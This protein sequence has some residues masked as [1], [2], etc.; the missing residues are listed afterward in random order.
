MVEQ[1]LEPMYETDYEGNPVLDDDGNKIP[2]DYGTYWI[3]EGLEVK[4][5]APTQADVDK[6]MALYN[7]IDSIYRYDE[8]VM[9]SITEVAGQYFAGDK[10]LDDAANLIQSKVKLYVNENK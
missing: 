9:N 8:N 2:V 10:P 3:S 7:E 6:I 1:A 4:M 5:E